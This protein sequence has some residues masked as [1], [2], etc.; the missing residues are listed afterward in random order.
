MIFKTY[1][2]S[3][4]RNNNLVMD[5]AFLIV[6]VGLVSIILSLALGVIANMTIPDFKFNRIHLCYSSVIIALIAY[7]VSFVSYFKSPNHQAH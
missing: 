1:N 3:G 7:P 5:M 6:A 4:K 2:E